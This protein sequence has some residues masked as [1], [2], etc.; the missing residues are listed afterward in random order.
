MWLTVP[1]AYGFLARVASGPR[2]SPFGQLA[3]R[4]LSPRLPAKMV[5]GPPKRFAQ[6]IGAVLS[7]G[8]VLTYFAFGSVG[9]ALAMVALIAVAAGLESVLGFCLGC[10]VFSVLMRHGVI[11]EQTCAACNDVQARLGVTSASA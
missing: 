8:S 4:A 7:V 11:P 2:Y 5:P 9:P 10:A 3:S 1:L 6:T